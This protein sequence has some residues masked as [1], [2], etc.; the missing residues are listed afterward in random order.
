MTKYLR[1]AKTTLQEAK[2]LAQYECNLGIFNHL[3]IFLKSTFIIQSHFFPVLFS[4]WFCKLYFELTANDY[5]GFNLVFSLF[6]RGIIF[7]F[8]I[9]QLYFINSCL[10]LRCSFKCWKYCPASLLLADIVFFLLSYVS[11]LHISNTLY[12]L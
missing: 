5:E 2:A 4:C 10:F 7:T 6:K 1:G 9:S 3:S 12:I 11:P 8:Q